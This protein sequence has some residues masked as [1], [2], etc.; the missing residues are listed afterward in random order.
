[1]LDDLGLLP[2]L[3]WYVDKQTQR[4]NISAKLVAEDLPKHLPP[5]LEI[6]CYRVTQEAI[7]NIIRHSEATQIKIELKLRD[8]E[9]HLK[10]Y[11]NGKGFEV[12]RARVKAAGG[13]SIGVLGMQERVEL[14]GGKLEINSSIGKGTV[15]HAIFP[16]SL[17][18]E[19]DD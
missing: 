6:T 2:A 11:D 7:T 5:N 1:M 8:E 12:N 3:R 16:I 9:L 13:S 18:K 4:A 15:I 14:I 10:I 19:Q 17:Y